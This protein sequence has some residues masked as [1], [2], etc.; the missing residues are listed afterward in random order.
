MP[1]QFLNKKGTNLPATVNLDPVHSS[2]NMKN[3]ALEI[4]IKKEVDNSNDMSAF[5]R[6]KVKILNKPKD[7]QGLATKAQNTTVNEKE[8]FASSLLAAK[9]D[10][11]ASSSSPK[12]SI[13]LPLNSVN[14]KKE[15]YGI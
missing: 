7:T 9:K 4:I 15:K 13:Y 3:D 6:S 10:T 1:R 8:I 2:N 12:S 11:K 14:S 5:K